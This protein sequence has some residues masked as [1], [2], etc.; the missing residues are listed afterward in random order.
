M[1]KNTGMTRRNFLEIS[2]GMAAIAASVSITGVADS[3][4]P[5]R[6]G[7]CD[8]SMQKGGNLEAFPLAYEIGL[9]G[10]EASLL[11]GSDVQYLRKP[12][13]Q[14]AYR[15][16]SLQY[17]IQIPSLAIG[18]LNSVP[19]KS[20]PKAALWVADSI[21]AARNVGAECILLAFFGKGELRMGDTQD[22]ERVVDVLVDLAPEAKKN[23][24]VLGLENTLSAEDNLRILERINSPAVQVYYDPKNSAA[25]GYNVLNEVGMLKGMICQVHL[26]NGKYHLDYRENLD[27]IALADAFRAINYQGWYIL[28][29]S[30]PNDVVSDTRA[31]IE[32]V[33]KHY[34]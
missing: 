11:S 9:N 15:E 14:D 5:L 17:G 26:K 10:V 18:Q 29:T 8:W 6:I 23:G 30:N 19:L 22:I 3:K 33:K 1:C 21:E 25:N 32:F 4:T 16:A 34:A 27:F 7:M 31:N 2:A 28:E 20:E 24:I 13:I 12:E